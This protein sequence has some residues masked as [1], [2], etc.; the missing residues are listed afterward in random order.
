M[1]IQFRIADPNKNRTM[2]GFQYLGLKL[3]PSITN[4]RCVNPPIIIPKQQTTPITKLIMYLVNP[5]IDLS[6]K[7][8]KKIK[9]KTKHAFI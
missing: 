8:T 4:E 7:Q 1:V 2:V 3:A 5:F 9:G 6:L